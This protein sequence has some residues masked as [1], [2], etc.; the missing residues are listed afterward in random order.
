VNEKLVNIA[1]YQCKAGDVVSLREK[2]KKQTRIQAALTIASQVGFPDWV[3]SGRQE[4]LGN[5]EISSRSAGISA[6]HQREPGRRVVFQVTHEPRLR[7]SPV[8]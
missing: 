1:S 8:S 3:G 6:G 2:A 4:V 5:S 7:V